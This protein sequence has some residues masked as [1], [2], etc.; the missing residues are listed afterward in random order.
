[1]IEFLISV[2]VNIWTFIMDNLVSIIAVCVAIIGI[3]FGLKRKGFSYYIESANAVVSVEENIA[4]Q[5][6]VFLGDR[7]IENAH[8][9]T[10]NIRNSG[11]QPIEGKDFV[12]DIIFDFGKDALFISAVVGETDPPNLYP[13]VTRFDD[14][15]ILAPLLI[16]G[17]DNFT[18][19]FLVSN[20]DPDTFVIHGRIVGVKDI[21]FESETSG[22]TKAIALLALIPLVLIYILSFLKIFTPIQALFS[23]IPSF[24][25]IYTAKLTS[26]KSIRRYRANIKK[27]RNYLER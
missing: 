26:R 5:V 3:L 14:V 13:I 18:V 11:N 9:I 7:Q 21:K 24:I 2:V 10:I 6:K 27:I 23:L 20:W 25:L 16:N 19:S 22:F 17:G 8:L 4:D 12:D 15:A 1:M